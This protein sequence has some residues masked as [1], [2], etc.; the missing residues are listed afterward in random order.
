MTIRTVAVPLLILWAAGL[1]SAQAVPDVAGTWEIAVESPQGLVTLTATMKAEEGK[2]TGSI[3]TQFGTLPLEG[4]ISDKEIVFGFMAS[5]RG[6]EIPITFNG[7]PDAKQMSGAADFG[8]MAQG[9]WS[10][11]K[12]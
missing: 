8:G 11:Q 2:I 9:T 4:T 7:T 3:E 6:R 10:A 5:V 1:S 12:K